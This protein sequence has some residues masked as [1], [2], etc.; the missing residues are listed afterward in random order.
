MQGNHSETNRA[1]RAMTKCP[2]PLHEATEFNLH[3][4][5]AAG[6]PTGFKGGQSYPWAVHKALSPS[7]RMPVGP[8]QHQDAASIPGELRSPGGS[9]SLGG[10]HNASVVFCR[11]LTSINPAFPGLKWT[12]GHVETPFL[13]RCFH[14]SEPGQRYH[15]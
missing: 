11:Y 9:Q 12:F 10:A 15:I 3:S 14:L 1:S 4:E 7:I 2:G 8:T 6:K 13:C 5:R